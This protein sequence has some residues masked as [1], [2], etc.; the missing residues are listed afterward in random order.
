MNA[1][2]LGRTAPIPAR[3]IVKNNSQMDLGVYFILPT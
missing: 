1:D 3:N 2:I